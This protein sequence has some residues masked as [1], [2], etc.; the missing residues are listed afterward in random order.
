MKDFIKRVYNAWNYEAD[1]AKETWLFKMFLYFMCVLSAVF[2][3]LFY[4]ATIVT[5]PLWVIPY[6]IYCCHKKEGTLK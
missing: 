1:F 3:I 2:V 6:I 4:A 5:A